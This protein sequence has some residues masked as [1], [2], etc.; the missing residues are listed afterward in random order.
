M[1]LD[2]RKLRI[3]STQLKKIISI[4]LP[5]GIQGSLFSISNVLIQSAVNSL[6]TAV[7][8]G[9]TI[10]GNLT[11]FTYTAM[12]CFYSSTLA[13][14]GQ[15]YGAGKHDRVNKVLIIGIIQVTLVGLITGFGELLFADPLV[16]IYTDDPLIIEAAKYKMLILLTTYFTCGIMEVLVGSLRGIGCSFVPMLSSIF[17]ACILRSWWTVVIFGIYGT[18]FSLYISYPISWIVTVILHLITLLVV[19]RKQKLKLEG[20][21]ATV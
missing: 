7:I 16:R 18:E 4:G 2:L 19:K 14:T 9:N 8:A 10:A 20:Q 13:F 3:Y 11:G 21:R 5:A 15:N 1:H 12:N 17:G 6:S